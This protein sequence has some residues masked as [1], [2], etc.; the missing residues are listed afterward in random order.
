MRVAEDGYN[1][2]IYVQPAD[3]G[4][5]ICLTEAMDRS[6]RDAVSPAWSGDGEWVVFVGRDHGAYPLFRVRAKGGDLPVV[7]VGGRRTVNGFSSPDRP[8][9]SPSPRPNRRARRS[10]LCATVMAR[11]SASSR[12]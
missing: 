6:V 2:L 12:I 3:G 5:R 11:V 10:Y 7:V 4:D 8:E 9:V 1:F